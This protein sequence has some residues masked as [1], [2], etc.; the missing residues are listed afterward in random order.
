MYIS[1][2]K[3]PRIYL[4]PIYRKD[5]PKDDRTFAEDK[6]LFVVYNDLLDTAVQLQR[7]LRRIKSINQNQST[8]RSLNGVSI[9]KMEC[10]WVTC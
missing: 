7:A 1:R 9:L 2:N 3:G 5:L 10:T 8:L 6:T 4:I